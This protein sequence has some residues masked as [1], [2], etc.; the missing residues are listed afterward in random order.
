MRLA[1]LTLIAAADL[2]WGIGVDGSLPWKV[3]EDLKHFRARTMDKTVVLGRKTFD[4]LPSSLPGRRVAVVSRQDFGISV[5]AVLAMASTDPSEILIAGGAE[6]YAAFLP[7]CGRA[8]ITRIRGVFPC[9]TRLSDISQQGWKIASIAS[10]CDDADIETW[11]PE[12]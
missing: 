12:E 3:P 4:T 2:E 9:D 6:I 11:R 1:N 10:L 5:E 8:E 7:H